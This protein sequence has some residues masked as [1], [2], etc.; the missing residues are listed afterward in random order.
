MQEFITKWAFDEELNAAYN[1][2]SQLD[3]RSASFGVM[4]KGT[5]T[6]GMDWRDNPAQGVLVQ[7]NLESGELLAHKRGTTRYYF[8]VEEVEGTKFAFVG[9][10]GRDE[11]DVE[12]FA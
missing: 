4:N 6:V 8:K 12:A 3:V 5:L 7:V 1:R 11:I 9:Q 2:N 10:S